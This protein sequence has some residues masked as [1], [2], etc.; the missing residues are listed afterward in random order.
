MIVFWQTADNEYRRLTEIN[1]HRLSRR[2][3]TVN[4]LAEM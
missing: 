3:E 1:H 2:V 4:A